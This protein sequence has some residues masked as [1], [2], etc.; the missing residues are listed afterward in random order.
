MEKAM[1]IMVMVIAAIGTVALVVDKTI[2]WAA[3]AKLMRLFGKC[4]PVMDKLIKE[5]EE[6]LDD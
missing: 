4:E 5:A 6:E 1:K 2:E 3:S